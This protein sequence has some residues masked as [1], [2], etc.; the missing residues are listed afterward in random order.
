MSKTNRRNFLKTATAAGAGLIAAPHISKAGV[1]NQKQIKSEVN[2][3]F[4]GVGGRGRG[5]LKR[6]GMTEGVNI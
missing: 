6:A 4:I 3:G 2:I 1:S 5:H